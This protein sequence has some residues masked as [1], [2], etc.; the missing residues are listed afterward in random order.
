MLP[1]ILPHRPDLESMD[2]DIPIA[3]VAVWKTAIPQVSPMKE[4][5]YERRAIQQ[6]IS[7]PKGK[8][9][10]EDIIW[11]V[12][13]KREIR[14]GLPDK[15]FK[16]MLSMGLEIFEESAFDFTQ[17]GWS[18]K[19]WRPWAM[20]LTSMLEDI[21]ITAKRLLA[22]QQIPE[23]ECC[24]KT[25]TVVRREKPS[26]NTRRKT[27][28]RRI[29]SFRIWW[30]IERMNVPTIEEQLSALLATYYPNDPKKESPLKK[31]RTLLLNDPNVNNN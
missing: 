5:D 3:T 6:I 16:T 29:M 26:I 8:I 4:K 12:G 1:P 21:N 27:N 13:Y 10:P 25:V 30:C 31:A 23:S 24:V 9:N 22:I 20:S 14:A 19:P 2:V 11:E 17:G 7:L 18:Q 28:R 15:I